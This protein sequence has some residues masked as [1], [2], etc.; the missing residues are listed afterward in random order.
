MIPTYRILV[1]KSLVEGSM[2]GIKHSAI[3]PLLKKKD[4]DVD[5]KKNYRPV[6][7][8]VFLSKSIER[9]VTKRLNS[10][11]TKNNLH[12]KKQFAYKEHH[13]TETMMAGVAN[14]VLSGFD[15]NKC[16][17]MIFL[18]LSAAFDTIDIDKMLGILS[19]EIGLEGIALQWCSSFLRNRTQRVKI[20]GQYLESIKVKY[21]TAQGSVL[22]A[23][24]YNIYVKRQPVIIENCGFTSTAFAAF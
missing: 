13:S 5:L 12:N 24:F 8:L 3:D 17:V 18:D 10:H 6:N 4:L 1:N 11:M 20:D 16:T 21:G 19:D 7:N 2:E 15:E 23:K 22:G 14:D 9:V